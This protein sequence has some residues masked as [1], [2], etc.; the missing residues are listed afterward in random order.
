MNL[1]KYESKREGAAWA[2]VSGL[3]GVI[4]YGLVKLA[5]ADDTYAATLGAAVAA[6][7]RDVIGYFLPG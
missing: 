3:L 7:A 4:A 6:G 5:G 2:G 1:P